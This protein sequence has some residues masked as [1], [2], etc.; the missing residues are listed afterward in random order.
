VHV[1]Q[2]AIEDALQD[3]D[4]AEAKRLY[5]ALLAEQP[6]WAD[7]IRALATLPDF[8]GFKTLLDE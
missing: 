5:A 1:Q 3:G 2:L 7:A 8:A 6:R 4:V